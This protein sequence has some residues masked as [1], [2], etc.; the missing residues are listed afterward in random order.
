M[1]MLAKFLAKQLSHPSGIV[2]RLV[3]ASLWNKRNAALNNI[4][5]DNLALQPHDRVLEVGFGG[6]YL[7]GRMATVVTEGFLAGVD[8]SSAMVAVCE[9]RY[10]LLVKAGK[11]E[12]K[13][14]Q[15][16]ALPYAA[17]DFTKVC[18]VNSI[19]Y[20]E[21]APQAIVECYRVL[22][23]DGLLVLC[24]TDK[25]SLSHKE[26]THHGV[27]LYDTEEVQQMLA[28]AGFQGI[29]KTRFQDKYREFWCLKSKKSISTGS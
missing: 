28:S 29:E 14:A 7:L 1:N 3:L 2:G 4:V 16:E 23:E 15:A 6:G 9:K 19:F 10:Q 22:K 27:A 18:T 8:V 26:F 25:K 12:L 5:F 11:L 17:D 20:W 24:F 13:C 21:N